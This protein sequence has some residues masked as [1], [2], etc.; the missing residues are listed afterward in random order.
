MF[1]NGHVAIVQDPVTLIHANVF[2]MA[3]A[4]EPIADAIGRIR[5]AG[6]EVTSVRRLELP[7]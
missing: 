5:T 7:A 4:S 1:W 3:V 6:S 2:H